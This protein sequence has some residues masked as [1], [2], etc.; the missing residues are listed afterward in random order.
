[1]ELNVKYRM[2]EAELADDRTPKDVI[3]ETG[4]VV[5]SFLAERDEDE[6]ID[7]A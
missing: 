7:R 2:I 6:E 1:M 4:S 3:E 5:E